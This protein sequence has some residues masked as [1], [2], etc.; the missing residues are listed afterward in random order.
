VQSSLTFWLLIGILAILVYSTVPRI[1]SG[2]APKSRIVAA[3]ADIRGGIKTSLDNYKMDNG[4]FPKSLNDLLQR[5]DDAKSWHGPY[6]EQIPIDPWGDNYIYEFPG[7]H[8]PSSYDL[9]SAGPDG[10]EG[11]DDDIGNWP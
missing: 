10:K 3:Q 11:T 7:K 9:L 1:S 5:A 2:G 8:N 4:F 6:L